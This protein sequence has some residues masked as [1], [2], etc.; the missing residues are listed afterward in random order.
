MQIVTIQIMRLHDNLCEYV[1]QFHNP[2]VH[3]KQITVLKLKLSIAFL[4]PSE[5][6]SFQYKVYTY[7]L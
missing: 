1:F 6:V 4:L 5:K 7:L 2:E 3:R